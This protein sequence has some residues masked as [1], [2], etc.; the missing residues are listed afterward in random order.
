MRSSSAIAVAVTGLGLI[1]RVQVSKSPE[2]HEKET[3]ASAPKVQTGPLD[4]DWEGGRV[5]GSMLL[6]PWV[7]FHLKTQL[8]SEHE[9]MIGGSEQKS[10][11]DKLQPS[12][13]DVQPPDLATE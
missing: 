11:T 7:G 12:N 8:H 4:G 6:P 9:L 2:G 13:R 5:R 3:P 1:L 10:W